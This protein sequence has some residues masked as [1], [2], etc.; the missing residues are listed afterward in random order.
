MASLLQKGARP[1]IDSRITDTVLG[2]VSVAI[3]LYELRAVLTMQ[4]S[5]LIEL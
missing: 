4:D 3:A 2:E 1:M 5:E